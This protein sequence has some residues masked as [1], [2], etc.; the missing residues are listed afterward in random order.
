MKNYIDPIYLVVTEDVWQSRVYSTIFNSLNDS[1]NYIEEVEKASNTSY[2]LVRFKFNQDLLSEIYN[3][4]PFRNDPKVESFYLNLFNKVISELT[5]RFDW[6]PSNC[7]IDDPISTIFSCINNDVP[8][9]V[10]SVWISLI[11]QCAICNQ[12]EPFIFFSPASFETKII[13]NPDK[14]IDF[15]QT[16]KIYELFSVGTFLNKGTI[17]SNSFKKAIEILYQQSVNSGRMN[18]EDNPQDFYFHDIFWKTLENAKFSEENTHYKQRFVDSLTQVIYA[19]DIDIRLH[20]YGKIS[21]DKKKYDKYSADVFQ[22]GRGT[23][24]RRCSRI[25]FCKINN[26]ICFYEF[27]PDFHSGE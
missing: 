18:S 11:N 3:H 14:P 10:L 26:Q 8:D 27:D 6:C 16:S 20:K 19:K 24:D 12:Q 7:E 21:I 17:N 22:M 13:V 25:F 9:E 1:L 5:R 4:N 23:N 2:K 15:T